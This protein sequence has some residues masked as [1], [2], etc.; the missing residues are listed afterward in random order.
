MKLKVIQK[1]RTNKV[2]A[3]MSAR[4]RFLLAPPFGNYYNS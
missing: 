3:P 4:G 2:V 1:Q